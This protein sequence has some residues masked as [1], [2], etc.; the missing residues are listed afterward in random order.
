MSKQI[1]LKAVVLTATMFTLAGS[2]HSA[3]AQNAKT[4]RSSEGRCQT[5]TVNAGADKKIAYRCTINIAYAPD[6]GHCR[7]VDSETGR[8]VLSDNFRGDTNDHEVTTRTTGAHYCVVEAIGPDRG[9][10][11]CKIQ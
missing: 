5:G 10:A 11:Y 6:L 2:M 4:C 9:T 7:I 3:W 8:F 1:T